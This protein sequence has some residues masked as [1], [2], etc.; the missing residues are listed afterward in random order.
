[1]ADSIDQESLNLVDALLGEKDVEPANSPT[2]AATA[3]D[4][5]AILGEGQ[6]DFFVPL[7]RKISEGIS[8]S[9]IYAL[10]NEAHKNGEDLEWD[11]KHMGNAE[12]H[13]GYT[14]ALLLSELRR[15][16]KRKNKESKKP[17]PALATTDHRQDW[18]YAHTPDYKGGDDVPAAGKYPLMEKRRPKSAATRGRKPSV[19]VGHFDKSIRIPAYTGNDDLKQRLMYEYD[20]GREDDWSKKLKDHMLARHETKSLNPDGTPNPPIADENEDQY[21]QALGWVPED[22]ELEESIEMMENEQ[23]PQEEEE[24]EG[25]EPAAIGAQR[26]IY[27]ANVENLYVYTS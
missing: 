24:K 26:T 23:C 15:R 19:R 22:E 25:E 9:K 5:D 8:R 17:G 18:K 13:A 2:S 27:I 20:K 12:Y 7:R 14:D 6:A 10:G 11:S 21:Y 1:M 4:P 3:T 16:E